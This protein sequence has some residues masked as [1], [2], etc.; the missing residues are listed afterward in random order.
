MLLAE[1]ESW[2]ERVIKGTK[3]V[4]EIKEYNPGIKTT[5]GKQTQQ[6]A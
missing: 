1:T 2:L 6:R 3:I 5:H 4:A